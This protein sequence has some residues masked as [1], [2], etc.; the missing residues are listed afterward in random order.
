M[1][2]N[3]SC[4]KKVADGTIAV[5]A[6]RSQEQPLESEVSLKDNLGEDHLD[7][8]ESM[9]SQPVF[10]KE[11]ALYDKAE[12]LLLEALEG[13]HLKLGDSHPQTLESRNNLIGL[14]EASG[15]PEQ[16]AKWRAELPQAEAVE[17]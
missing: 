7:T 14:Y 12:P 9:K 2:G 13:G 11:Q 17:E 8:P 1:G 4:G 16:A 10:Y 15:K 6:V 3:R 5:T